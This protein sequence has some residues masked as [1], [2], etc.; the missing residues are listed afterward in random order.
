MNT[1]DGK[2]AEPQ[3]TTPH[4]TIPT[5]TSFGAVPWNSGP[6]KKKTFKKIKKKFKK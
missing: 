6:N 3:G 2:P 1:P 5:T 4:E